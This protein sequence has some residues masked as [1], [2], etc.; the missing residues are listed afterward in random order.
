[1]RSQQV[2]LPVTTRTEVGKG[3]ARRLRAQGM[4]PAVLYGRGMKSLSVSVAASQFARALSETGWYSTL[5]RLT[6][7][8]GEVA[9]RDPA[10]MVS[11]VQRDPVR[12]SLLSIDF[13][14]VSM[15]ENIHTQIP[16]VHVNQSP[17]VKRGGIL[18]HI[19]HE[20]LVECLPTDIPDHFEA[21]ISGMDIGDT[22]RVRDLVAPPGVQIQSPADETVIVIAPPVK[23]EE[24]AAPAA[25][26]GAAVEETEEPELVG[27][28]ESEE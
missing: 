13:H 1:M 24:E 20:V 6:I 23:L 2:R 14:R 22:L 5:L 9:E 12:R 21:D 19:M 3:A 27:E 15:Q 10:V 18:E 17:G 11:E 8:G 26:E 7:E 4:I 28:R 25:E 16:V